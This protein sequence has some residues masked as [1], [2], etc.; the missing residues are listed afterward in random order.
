MTAIRLYFDEDSMQ[1]ALVDA[2]RLRDVDVLTALEAEMVER[3]DEEHLEYA[4]SQGRTLS[5]FNVGDFCRLHG[6]FLSAGRSHYGIILARQQQYSV[7]EQMRRILKLA[8]TLSAEEMQDR[9]EFLSAW[10]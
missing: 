9:I 4:A 10:G 8:A 7:G 2:L 1:H 3:E 6:E 5:T